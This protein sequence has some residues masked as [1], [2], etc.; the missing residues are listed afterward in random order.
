MSIRR[1]SIV[2]ELQLLKRSDNDSLLEKV[3]FIKCY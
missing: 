3:V 2:L 1:R